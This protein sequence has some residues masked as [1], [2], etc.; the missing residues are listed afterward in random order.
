MVKKKRAKKT[1]RTKKLISKSKKINIVLRNLIMFLILT[2]FAFVIYSVTGD[3]VVSNIT[4]LIALV[5]GCVS[6]GLLISFLILVF[7]KKIKK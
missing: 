2:I 7:M 3:E 1:Q 5:F 4:L 6:I